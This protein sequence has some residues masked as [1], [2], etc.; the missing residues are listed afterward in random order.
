MITTVCVLALCVS[1]PLTALGRRKKSDEAFAPYEWESIDDSTWAAQA[2]EAGA[3]MLFEKIL[4]DDREWDD[5]RCYRTLYRRIRITSDEGKAHA[6]VEAPYL[7]RKQVVLDVQGRTVLPSGDEIA[8][9]EDNIFEKDII[10][11]KDERISQ[12]SFSLPGVTD[13][14]IIEYVIRYRTPY[15]T[16]VWIIQK[17]IPLTYGECVWKYY[18]FK[19]NDIW[20]LWYI[21]LANP[22]GDP[23]EAQYAWQNVTFT[24]RKKHRPLREPTEYLFVVEDVPSLVDESFGIS[25]DA[26]SAKLQCF[27]APKMLP[28]VF[29]SNLTRLISE[30]KDGVFEDNK[31]IRKLASEFSDLTTDSEKVTEAYKWLHANVYNLSYMDEEEVKERLKK[32]DL[33]EIEEPYDI[34]SSN[35]GD[36]WDI[37]LTF[38]ALL[39]E[40]GI[41]ASLGFVVDRTDGEFFRDVL[42]WQFDRELI[43][44]SDSSGNHDFYAPGEQYLETGNVPWF[45]EGTTALLEGP[46]GERIAIPYSPSSTTKSTYAYAYTVNDDLTVSG[47]VQ[48]QVT[49]HSARSL[50]LRHRSLDSGQVVEELS[51]ETGELYASAEV[52]SVTVSGMEDMS[53]PIEISYELSFPSATPQGNRILLKPA[54]Y[55]PEL[56]SA[57]T[58]DERTGDIRFRYAYETENSASIKLPGGWTVEGVP[59]DTMFENAVGK[60]SIQ[61][62]AEGD[63]I[64]VRRSF[65]L[66]SPHWEASSYEQ[67][68]RLF[69]ARQELANG[70]V[71]LVKTEE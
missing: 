50:R 57:F 32:R 52:K 43:I 16:G 45:V 33:K 54:D 24:K 20:L 30:W 35:Y 11:V 59:G 38:C 9:T 41:D 13:D 62:G 66:S 26:G 36:R 49:G 55:L 70:I 18:T 3:V 6:D 28:V 60:C 19:E 8:L 14:C 17:D 29:W 1:I 37:N 56:S 25:E 44:V 12:T 63:S 10:R 65:V 46:E 34:I 22:E 51:G 61:Y 48:K 64:S 53:K 5:K 40:L 42:R 4:V 68:K 2:D 15:P 31:K 47:I 21:V 69:A 39:E 71:V 67:V 58:S 23:I 27:Y 7:N